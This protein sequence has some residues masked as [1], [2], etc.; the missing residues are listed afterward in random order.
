MREIHPV[1][2]KEV[3]HLQLREPGIGKYR[4]ITTKQTVG[5]ILDQCGVETFNDAW[6]HGLFSQTCDQFV[7][8][9]AMIAAIAETIK[10]YGKFERRH[11]TIAPFLPVRMR[12]GLIMDLEPVRTDS[13]TFVQN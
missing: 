9:A 12:T 2:L 13:E 4:T 8:R 10:M 7:K 5:R 6:C 3:L 11:E 1:S